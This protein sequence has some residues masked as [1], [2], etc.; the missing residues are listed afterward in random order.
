MIWII[1]ALVVIAVAFDLRR[2][3]I[4]DWISIMILAAG[5]LATGLGW[6]DV[7][8]L[9]FL[10]GLALGL[11]IAAPYFAFG[12]LGGGDVK[13]IASLGAVLG[14]MALMQSLFWIALAGGVLAVIAA[15]RKKRDFA[16]APAIALGLLVHL[17][18]TQGLID[19]VAG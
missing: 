16:Y 5:A 17:L 15:I 2:R 19:A 18:L 14:P 11:V 9:E 10:G 3:E 13:L 1:F 12:G 4:P 6:H 8:W 7:R